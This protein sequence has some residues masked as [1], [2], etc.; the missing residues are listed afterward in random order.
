MKIGQR[1]FPLG[2]H[3][4]IMGIL[5]MT[6]DSFSDGGK[7][8]TL[9]RALLHAEQ[10][11][12]EGVDVI[13]IGGESTRPGHI[14]ISV[15][16]EIERI[17]P[18]IERMKQDYEI[19]ISV[20]TYR[21]ETAKAALRAGADLIN[22]IW[23]FGYDKEIA[24]ITAEYQAAC[25][26]MHNRTNSDYQNMFEN[27]R[28][29]LKKS[30]ALARQAGIPDNQIILDP[31]VGFAKDAGQNMQV[32][33]GLCEFTTLG[34]PLLLGASKKSVIASIYKEPFPVELRAEGTYVTTM[35]AV[36]NH[37]AFVRVHDV[38]QN[39]RIIEMTE[40]VR[41]ERERIYESV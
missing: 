14:Q 24:G 1:K 41:S 16:E 30:V 34:Y 33:A 21:H 11:I 15:E 39:K 29:D 9:E 31:G 32:L 17:T 4:Y 2:E 19:P 36:M 18:V 22:D 6:P 12:K 5:N 10:M 13:D 3:T 26:L 25:C 23:G 37:Y 27:I 8:S 40:A 7:Y 28:T 38:A 20:D 35:L